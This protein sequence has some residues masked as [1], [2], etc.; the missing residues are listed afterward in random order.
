MGYLL[1]VVGY[2]FT[3]VCWNAGGTDGFA[4]AGLNGFLILLLVVGY[5]LSVVGCGLL[6]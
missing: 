2:L 6:L 1:L 3:L 5:L 4:S